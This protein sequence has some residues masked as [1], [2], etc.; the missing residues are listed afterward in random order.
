MFRRLS[1]LVLVLAV[2]APLAGQARLDPGINAKIRAEENAHSTIMHTLHML[3]D[4]YGPRMTG[5]PNLKAAGE[6]AIKE[7]QSWGFTNGRLEPWDFGHPGWVNE[8]FSAHVVSPV[9]DQLTAE[10]LAYT[11]GT[12]GTVTAQAVQLTMPDRPTPQ[13]LAS[14]LDSQKD[15]VRGRIVLVGKHT[16]V[17][18]EINPPAKRRPDDQVRAQYDPDNP[19]AGQFGRCGRGQSN[20]PP[21]PMT[22][23]QIDEKVDAFLVA[24]G[25]K[26]RVNDAARAHGQ[27][28][29]FNNRTFDVTKAV[30]TVVLRNE[31]YGRI[32]RILAD[33]T[34]VELEF[35]IVNKVYPEGRTAY[36]TVAE[37][38]GTDKKDEVVMLGGHL[39]SWHSATGATDNAIG[40]AT[41][42]EAARIL[43]AIGVAPRRTIRV[44]LWSGEEQGILG[45]QAYVKQHF[46]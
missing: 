20:E 26:V 9:Q 46:G 21:P 31:D 18:V 11:P 29:A 41:M 27:I 7:M 5:S 32:S 40:C 35:T 16:L 25:A 6:W 42:M 22:T 14:F 1:P 39:D 33:G 3:T 17:P 12:D 37:I 43:K 4:V 30:P 36:N 38:A 23:R 2:A 19:N 13:Q 34:P 15:K 44:A 8:R 24:S 28:I 10:V 45:S